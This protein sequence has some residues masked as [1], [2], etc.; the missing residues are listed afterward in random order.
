MA[1]K[2]ANA[3]LNANGKWVLPSGELIPDDISKGWFK[4]ENVFE[5]GKK[6]P[7]IGVPPIKLKKEEDSGREAIDKKLEPFGKSKKE[8]SRPKASVK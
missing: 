8:P 2:P 3:T 1:D 4:G 7:P 5:P 6:R